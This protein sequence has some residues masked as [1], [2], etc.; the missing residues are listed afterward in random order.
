VKLP[1]H[2]ITK[3]IFLFLL[4]APGISALAAD[5]KA[6][7]PTPPA[8]EEKE[9]YKPPTAPG[10]EEA[11]VEQIK[12]KY[13]ARGNETQLGV[14]Q[15]RLYPK[16]HRFEISPTLGSLNGDPFLSSYAF[17][18]TL[19]FHFSEFFAFHLVGWDASV[20][21]SSALKLLQQQLNTTANTNQPKWY[22]GGE[23]RASVLYGKLSLLGMAILYFDAYFSGG[24]GVIAT[25][26]GNNVL[27]S[28]GIGQ[29]I[30]LSRLISLNADFK[31]MYYRETIIGKAPG[32]LGQNLGVRTNLCNMVTLSLSFFLDPLHGDQS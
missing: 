16:R 8:K 13:W 9:E 6:E 14:V 5:K 10:A 26:T 20:T 24:L 4:A 28:L 23:A 11:D 1:R 22:F 31:L 19:G 25:E 7:T 27:G 18:A 32:D 15:N 3:L 17:G 2:P 12:Q 30:H 29:Q 21:P